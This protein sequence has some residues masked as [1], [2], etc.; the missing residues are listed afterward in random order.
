[1]KK[2][3]LSLSLLAG[4]I[5]ATAQVPMKF[6]YQGVARNSTGQPIAAQSLGLR[7]SIIDLTPDGAVVYQETQA[8]TTNAYGLY[9]LAIGNGTIVTGDMNSVNWATGD[10]YIKVE[11]D[12]D[13][14]TAYT[15]I[16]CAL[17]Y[18]C[19]LRYTW[20]RRTSRS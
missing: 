6:N 5:T 2:I 13:G 15:I 10:K 19:R 1:M 8:V 14:G 3:I 7:L 20:A 18:V 16:E 4:F 11:M 17:C 12:P 9:N